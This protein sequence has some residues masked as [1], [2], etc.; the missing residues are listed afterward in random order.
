MCCVFTVETCEQQ[1]KNGRQLAAEALLCMESPSTS[2]ESKTF[3][4]GILHQQT[5]GKIR[6]FIKMTNITETPCI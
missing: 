6:R 3:L 5:N 1:Q 4:Q 2:S